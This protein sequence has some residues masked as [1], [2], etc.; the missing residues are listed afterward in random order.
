MCGICGFSGL[1]DRPLIEAMA[2]SIR[3]RGPD[4]A[5]FFIDGDIALGHRRLSIIDVEG[6]Q[7]PIFN[8]DET[9]A[10]I[11]NG[12]IYN[13]QALREELIERGH[14]FRTHSDSEVVLHLYEEEGAAC[15]RRPQRHVRARDR[16]P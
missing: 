10:L 7:Q 13:Y 9:L 5:G 8:E 1:E 4:S 11:I 3:H 12:E 14:R 15:L 16:R 6:G 2:E